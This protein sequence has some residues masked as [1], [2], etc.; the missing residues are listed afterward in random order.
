MLCLCG[1]EVM[2]MV[3]DMLFSCAVSLAAGMLSGKG[4]EVDE[5]DINACVRY[6]YDALSE[7]HEELEAD[8]NR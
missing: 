6:C 1:R 4:D 8:S 3:D 5:A 2:K 7:V